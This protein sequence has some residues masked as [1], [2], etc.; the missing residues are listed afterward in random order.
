[1]IFKKTSLFTGLL[2]ASFSLSSSPV[3]DEFKNL[4]EVK[5]REV[6]AVGIDGT[7]IT[8]LIYA[9][10][11]YI[12]IKDKASLESY[13]IFLERNGIEKSQVDKIIS[14]LSYGRK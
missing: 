2:I 12:Q 4:F 6:T 1:M 7:E 5:S 10:Y 14:E 9:G 13:K 11:D 8:I 3:P